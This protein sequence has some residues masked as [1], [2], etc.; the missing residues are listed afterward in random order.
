[1]HVSISAIDVIEGK[2]EAICDTE[3]YGIHFTNSTWLDIYVGRN[4]LCEIGSVDTF[5]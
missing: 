1:M 5:E 2:K 4:S 3:V